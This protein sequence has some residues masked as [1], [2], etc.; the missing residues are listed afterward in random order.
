MK[1]LLCLSKTEK[2]FWPILTKAQST[3]WGDVENMMASQ[4][5]RDLAT[6]EEV[7]KAHCGEE[8][9]PD[10]CKRIYQG[11]QLL[12]LNNV[13]GHTAQHKIVQAIF[14]GI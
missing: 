12:Q 7:A 5:C 14:A 1:P 9:L 13:T 10:I 3:A 6:V 4:M 8:L 11:S 2:L